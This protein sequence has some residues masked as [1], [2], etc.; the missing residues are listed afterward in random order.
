MPT[1]KHRSHAQWQKI[2]QQQADSGLNVVAFCQQQGLSS[3]T[4]YKRR[5]QLHALADNVPATAFVKLSR[6]SHQ[7][8]NREPVPAGILHYRQS[9]LHIQPGCD[10]QWLAQLMQ[11]LS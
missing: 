9:Q 10:A 11:A 1:R 7:P 8:L 3:K 6:P 4:F 5:R 2:I